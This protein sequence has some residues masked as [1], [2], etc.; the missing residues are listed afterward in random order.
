MYIN[1]L[2]NRFQV[3]KRNGDHWYSHQMNNCLGT[4]KMGT[5]YSF[6]ILHCEVMWLSLQFIQNRNQF[7]NKRNRF[8]NKRNWF[9]NKRNQTWEKVVKIGTQP[10]GIIINGSGIKFGLIHLTFQ[11]CLN[12]SCF[13]LL[14]DDTNELYIEYMWCNALSWMKL[15]LCWAV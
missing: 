10:V 3:I 14:Q 13:C 15:S 11:E 9:M 12:S 7:M 2:Y 5:G 1:L 4:V 8:M 6:G